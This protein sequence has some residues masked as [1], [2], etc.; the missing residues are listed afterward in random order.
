MFIHSHVYRINSITY[1]FFTAHSIHIAA[2]YFSALLFIQFFPPSSILWIRNSLLWNAP[3][4]FI[5]HSSWKEKKENSYLPAKH[6]CIHEVIIKSEISIFTLGKFSPNTIFIIQE[7]WFSIH[8]LF[9]FYFFAL[10]YIAILKALAV[11]IN[12]TEFI[13]W[14]FFSLSHFSLSFLL[15]IAFLVPAVCSCSAS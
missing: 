10:H 14:G 12:I 6:I 13:M 11:A 9:P 1:S 2:K 4:L 3:S 8:C 15:N 7:G 5:L